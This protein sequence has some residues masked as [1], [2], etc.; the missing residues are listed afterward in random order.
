MKSISIPSIG[1]GNLQYPPDVVAKCLIE[2]A[3][4]YISK[5]QHKSLQLVHFVIF[6]KD[7]HQEFIKTHDSLKESG[8]PASNGIPLTPPS[9]STRLQHNSFQHDGNQP[10]MFSLPNSLRLEVVQE[11]IT[12]A[13]VDVVVNTTN[14]HLK[15]VGSGVASALAKK[16]GPSLQ[17]ACDSLVRQG[18]KVAEGNVVETPC[19]NMGSLRCKS[20]FHIVFSKHKLEQTIFACLERAEKM[21]YSSI[22]FPA[23]GTGGGNMSPHAAVNAVVNALKR[24]TSKRSQKSLNLIQIVLFQS[25][26]YVQFVDAF[27]K[28][29]AS[30]DGFLRRMINAVGSYFGYSDKDEEMEEVTE[31]GFE[32]Q[33]EE[34]E[35]D[36][37]NV[38]ANLPREAEVI[39]TIFGESQQSVGRAEKSLRAIIL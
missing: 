24:F 5:H 36:E 31:D 32:N 10:C 23:I 15:L 38:F 35:M 12:S 28:M 8:T 21:K 20:I 27:K 14:Q 22:A 19:A 13:C 39:I 30:S 33:F 7:I 37:Q 26:H 16:A 34:L 18:V 17:S 2:T 9:Q 4:E 29:E 25:D 6:D 11:D 1:A 3:A